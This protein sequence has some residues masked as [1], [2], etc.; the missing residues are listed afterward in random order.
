MNG[1][2]VTY[3]VLVLLCGFVAVGKSV[4]GYERAAAILATLIAFNEARY[5]EPLRWVMGM[6]QDLS[7]GI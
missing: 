5:G 1:I 3:G 4:K 7:A 6:L 2:D